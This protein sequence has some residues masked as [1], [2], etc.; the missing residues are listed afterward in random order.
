M[1]PFKSQLNPLR[2]SS[3]RMGIELS[4]RLV[5]LPP[6]GVGTEPLST[7]PTESQGRSLPSM[8]TT[9]AGTIRCFS[10]AAWRDP[11]DAGFGW[12]FFDHL[13]NS[14][15]HDNPSAA[16][17]GSPLLAEAIALSLAQK[18]AL[19]LGFRKVS[20]ASDS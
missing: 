16:N 6:L 11:G 18:Q 2:I 5:N 3:L 7:H 17:V 10:D 8:D 20:F 12:V 14:E 1:A 9:S 19:D 15:H 4:N 13:A